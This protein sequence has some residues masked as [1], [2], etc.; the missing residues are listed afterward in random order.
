MRHPHGA[1]LARWARDRLAQ[2][3]GGPPALAPEGDWRDAPGAT[4]VTLRRPDGEL[5]GCIGSLAPRRSILDDAAENAIAAGLH[6]PRST[7]VR[8][9]DVP[10]LDLELS[11]LSPQ[12]PIAF[13]DEASALAAIRPGVDGIVLQWNGHRAT[14]LPSMW[15]RLPDVRTFMGELKNKAGLPWDFWDD[16][17]RL[18]RYTVD[19][20]VDPPRVAAARA[21]HASS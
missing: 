13:T 21:V 2:E 3:L 1:E 8:L 20:H 7:P 9:E 6:D 11:I 4:F 16:D 18:F 17:V 12:E 15:P 19:K 10:T 14:F 5:Q